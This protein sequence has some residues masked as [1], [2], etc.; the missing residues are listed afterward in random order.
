MG[1]YDLPGFCSILLLQLLLLLLLFLILALFLACGLLGGLL[2]PAGA[3]GSTESLMMRAAQTPAALLA[4]YSPSCSM[5]S[6]GCVEAV[7]QVE[8]YTYPCS[9]AAGL[10]LPIL[11]AAH[12][13]SVSYHK[14][15]AAKA[16]TAREQCKGQ[17]ST[18]QR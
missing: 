17:R 8:A 15:C 11:S 12:D 13:S 2:L 3:M 6:L 18:E 10:R 14:S 7:I 9:L 1:S 5:Y 4:M 16:G